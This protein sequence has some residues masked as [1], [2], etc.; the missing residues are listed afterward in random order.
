SK[1]GR[2]AVGIP[3]DGLVQGGSSHS[4]EFSKVGVE[5]HPL[6]AHGADGRGNTLGSNEVFGHEN[7]VGPLLGPGTR[8]VSATVGEYIG[9]SLPNPHSTV[10][11]PDDGIE[12]R[13][14]SEGH[15]LVLRVRRRASRAIVRLNGR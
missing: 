12:Q 11:T 6:A 3:L 1:V 14:L 13:P 10:V 4:V 9:P 7:R 5:Q 8:T 15:C 2:E